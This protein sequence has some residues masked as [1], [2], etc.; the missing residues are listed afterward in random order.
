VLELRNQAAPKVCPSDPRTRAEKHA[1]TAV[2][3]CLFSSPEFVVGLQYIVGAQS[4][5]R[6]QLAHPL[7]MLQASFHW[8]DDLKTRFVRA[9][10]SIGAKPTK[11]S[12]LYAMGDTDPFKR[13]A[14]RVRQ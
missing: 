8:V 5:G 13:T 9:E 7:M 6:R 14:T 10:I 12:D 3:Y 4:Q 1:D 2:E 11:A